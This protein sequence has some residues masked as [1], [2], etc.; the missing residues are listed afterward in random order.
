MA[1][2]S[3]GAVV[4]CSRMYNVSPLSR[5]CWDELFHWLAAVSGVALEIIGHAAPA[6]LSALWQRTDLGMAFM[7]GY[8]YSQLPE[9]EQP[10]ALVSAVPN[11]EW[12]EGRA[13][14]ASYLVTRAGGNISSADLTALRWGWTVTDSQSGYHAPR[15]YLALTCGR[16]PGPAAHGPLLNPRGMIDAIHRGVVDIGAVDAFGYELLRR[17]DPDILASLAILDI[18]RPAPFP[19]LVASR[20]QPDEVVDA[21]RQSLLM[22]HEDREGR[23]RMA[24]LGIRR[25]ELP[26]MAAIRELSARAEIATCQLGGSW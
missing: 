9:E 13:Q 2:V 11:A 17:H 21:L 25:F 23:R 10:H 22:A 5:Q 26:D 15:E 12:S 14:Y 16:M 20:S 3:R 7:C 24:A 6:S 4:A 19:P 18:T 8:P 1:T